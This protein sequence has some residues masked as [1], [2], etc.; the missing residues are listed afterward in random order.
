MIVFL[1]GQKL[2]GDPGR[3]ILGPLA[4]ESG[5]QQLDHKLGVDRPL[6]TQY[7]DWVT[8]L[9]H[10]DMGTSYEYQA[11]I[12]PMIR[13][14]LVNSLKLALVAFIMCVPL[15]NPPDRAM[16]GRSQTD[17]TGFASYS[18]ALPIIRCRGER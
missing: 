17:G 4:A 10:G 2:P 18:T 7:K 8:N 11:P 16:C 15:S 6:V 12:E 1:A 5:V 13:A 3:A 9:L 14:A